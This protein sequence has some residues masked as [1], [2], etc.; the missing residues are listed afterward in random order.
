MPVQCHA[1]GMPSL[2]TKGVGTQQIEEQIKEIFPE[3]NV[4]R[5]DWDSTRGKWGFDRIIEAFMQERIQILV[6]TQMV[7]RA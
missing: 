5:M 1:C 2:T 6:G 4:G 7:V 3:T